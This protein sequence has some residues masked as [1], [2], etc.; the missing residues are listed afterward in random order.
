DLLKLLLDHTGPCEPAEPAEPAE[1]TGRAD[2]GERP[3]WAPEHLD[4]TVERLASMST[5]Q[6]A[7]L[8][9]RGVVFVHLTDTSLLQQAGIARVEAQG[10]MLVQSLAE[11]LGHADVTL[12][13]VLDHRIRRRVD[14]YEHPE[15]LKDH[16]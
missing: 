12:R 7:C 2:L 16:V 8:R 1:P 15:L 9:G 11:L 3:V 4:S 5:R 13:P 10:P 6:L 14:A